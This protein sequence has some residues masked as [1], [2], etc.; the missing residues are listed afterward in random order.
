[1]PICSPSY[2]QPIFFWHRCTPALQHSREEIKRALDT[3]NG[4]DSYEQWKKAA[5][6]IDH[7]RATD[8][9]RLQEDSNLFDA[10]LIRDLVE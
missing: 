4:A 10:K 3:L 6:L 2:C 5:V 8:K 1:M 9:W 7:V